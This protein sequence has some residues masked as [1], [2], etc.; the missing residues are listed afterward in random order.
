MID[1]DVHNDWSSSNVLLPY[2]D[3]NFKDYLLRG[4]LPGPEVLFPMPIAP[5]YTQKTFVGM[6]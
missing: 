1:C 4:E 5:G 2:I 3:A 6:I